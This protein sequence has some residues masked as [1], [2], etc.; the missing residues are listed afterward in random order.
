MRGHVGQ[1]ERLPGDA[2]V[3]VQPGDG[4]GCVGLGQRLADA[5]DVVG[6][7]PVETERPQLGRDRVGA[8]LASLFIL[9]ALGLAWIRQPLLQKLLKN[10]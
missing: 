5:P 10:T 3:V 1:R 2:L 7:E 6:C 4:S 9:L 8:L